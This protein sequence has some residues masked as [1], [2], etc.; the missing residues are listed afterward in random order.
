[1]TTPAAEKR[2]TERARAAG[3]PLTVMCPTC[4]EWFASERSLMQHDRLAHTTPSETR[5]PLHQCDQCSQAFLSD[6]GLDV[7]RGR[8]HRASPPDDLLARLRLADAMGK[9]DMAASMLEAADEIERLRSAVD[10]ILTLARGV[11]HDR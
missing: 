3:H 8:M 4:S 2:R 5:R 1:V 6:H 7:H 9:A 10:Q 11:S